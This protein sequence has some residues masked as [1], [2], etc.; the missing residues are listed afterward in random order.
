MSNFMD[1]LGDEHVTEADFN[2]A[3][4]FTNE[5]G[6]QKRLKEAAD[7][8]NR[9]YA[10]LRQAD[11]EYDEDTSGRVFHLFPKL[12]GEL[13]LH[14]WKHAAK[15]LPVPKV[16]AFDFDLAYDTSAAPVGRAGNDVIACFKPKYNRA[17]TGHRGLLMACTDSRQA[18][19]EFADYTMQPLT[20]LV[21]PPV[22][23]KEPETFTE[24]IDKSNKDFD[25]VCKAWG[26]HYN[27]SPSPSRKAETKPKPKEAVSQNDK[28]FVHV[29][30]PINFNDTRFLIDNVADTFS[31]TTVHPTPPTE[32]CVF[33]QAA[34]LEIMH[35]IKKLAISTKQASFSTERIF[36]DF[37][38]TSPDHWRCAPLPGPRDFTLGALEELTYVSAKAFK[39]QCCIGHVHV[40]AT[41][42]S[43]KLQTFQR[44]PRTGSEAWPVA[45]L[46]RLHVTLMDNWRRY[47]RR[48]N[49]RWLK[50]M[51]Q[52][53]KCRR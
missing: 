21:S 7:N 24:Y 5:S 46:Y 23:K 42:P 34:G 51:K 41:A 48:F 25:K 49:H 17:L 45:D 27:T 12:P 6:L 28:K 22:E 38:A 40:W 3:M 37:F 8:F 53:C 20:Y 39:R 18:F 32:E 52:P 4:G 29:I 14:V 2:Y 1:M 16:Q 19:L 44:G 11:G 9:Q 15:G 10:E 33:T 31:Y 13:Q 35:K 36:S 26:R 30:L 47:D 50:A 43:I